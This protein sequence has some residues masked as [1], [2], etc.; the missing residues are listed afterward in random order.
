MSEQ[1]IWVFGPPDRE[2]PNPIADVPDHGCVDVPDFDTAY[3][4]GRMYGLRLDFSEEAW[5]FLTERQ[6]TMQSRRRRDHKPEPKAS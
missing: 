4:L 5:T 6:T 3:A 1:S 2:D